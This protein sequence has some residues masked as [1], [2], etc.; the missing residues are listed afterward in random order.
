MNAS[1]TGHQCQVI[2]RCVLCVVA[3]KT[4]V[5]DMYIS[6]FL[7]DTG[8]L[9]WGKGKA[10]KWCLLAFLV[11]GEDGNLPLDGY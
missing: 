11:S 9:E 3:T 10:Q 5:E 6:S 2:K 1:P 4:K 7:I 8:N